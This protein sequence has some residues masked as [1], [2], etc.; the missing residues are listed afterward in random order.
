MRPH[1]IRPAL[2]QLFEFFDQPKPGRA[3]LAFHGRRPGVDLGFAMVE[4]ACCLD[5]WAASWAA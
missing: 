3:D 1:S 5:N 4:R 2:G